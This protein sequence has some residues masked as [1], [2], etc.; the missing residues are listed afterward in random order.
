MRQTAEIDY[1]M[2]EER[3]SLHEKPPGIETT[4]LAF[5]V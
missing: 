5:R 4:V 2:A 1:K 3:R